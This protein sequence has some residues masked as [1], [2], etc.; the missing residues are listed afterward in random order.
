MR[1]LSCIERHTEAG[2][3]DEFWSLE[4]VDR[5][6]ALA[7]SGA[8]ADVISMKLGRDVAEVEAKLADLGIVPGKDRIAQSKASSSER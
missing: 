7:K 4:A 3:T 2:M 1:G 5:L 6:V 8:A